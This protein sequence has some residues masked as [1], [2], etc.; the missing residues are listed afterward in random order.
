MPAC[1]FTPDL[2][3]LARHATPGR[4]REL[5][6]LRQAA[7][8]LRKQPLESF[9]KPSAAV[10]GGLMTHPHPQRRGLLIAPGHRRLRQRLDPHLG[11]DP[12]STAPPQSH[13]RNTAAA[14]C[15][16]LSPRDQTAVLQDCWRG[17]GSALRGGIHA[18][19][20]R[21]VI[22]GDSDDSYDFSDLRLF[23]E[24]LREGY[25]LV[26]GNRFQGGIR[27]G[28][29]PPLHRYL[30]NPVLTTIGR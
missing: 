20:G 7:L 24:K 13:R 8:H 23:V 25:Q 17:A 6:R 19:R 11:V 3:G 15:A 2:F 10:P 29:M 14:A 30:G 9:G 18:A 28:A 12:P 21:Y 16:A 22:M 27:T 5:A 1:S 26:M 4:D